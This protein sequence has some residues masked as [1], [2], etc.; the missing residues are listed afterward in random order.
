M[1]LVSGLSTREHD[2]VDGESWGRVE[3]KAWPGNQNGWSAGRLFPL[4]P[5]SSLL[6][7]SLAQPP[8]LWC[9]MEDQWPH[10]LA[11][12]PPSLAGWPPLGAPIIGL[13][14][15]SLL[16]HLTSSQA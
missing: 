7:F 10:G 4:F 1:L 14:K 11:A 6:T 3:A 16:L 5:L 13:A 9:I 8:P 2:E 15:G 12:R